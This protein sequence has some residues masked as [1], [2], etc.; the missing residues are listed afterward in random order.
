MPLQLPITTYGMDIL[1]KETKPVENI[2][3]K[4]IELVDNMFYTMINANG[5]GLAAPQVNSD[6]AVCIVD[7]SM[8]EEYKDIKPLILINP[9]ILDSHGEIVKEEGCLSIPEVRAEIKRPDK[10]FV[11]FNDF[12]QNEVKM[13][14]SGYQARVVQHEIDHLHGKLFI[15]Y[16]SKEELKEY[17]S[18]LRKIQKHKIAT[19]Y[20]L[21]EE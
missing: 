7:I 4:I 3:T 19:D 16:L 1:R 14:I 17:K 18:Q 6:L 12:N 9:V 8:I 2:D 13:E 10:I 21:L 11:K 20:P 15:D 5:I